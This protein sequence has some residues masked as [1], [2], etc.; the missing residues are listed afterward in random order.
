MY[1]QTTS[2]NQLGYYNRKYVQYQLLEGVKD[3]EFACLGGSGV[4]F[5]GFK[6]KCLHD[7]ELGLK[8]VNYTKNKPNL[9]VSVA[10]YKNIP[11]FTF[12][13][14]KRRDETSEWFN[15]N[16]NE[17]M[18]F[19]LFFDFDLGKDDTWESLI[20]EVNELKE[21]LDDYQVPYFVFFS[22]N[23]GVQVVIDGEYIEINE[24]KEG[25]V[26]PHKKVVENIKESL[27]L[28]TLDLS[29]NGEKSK[30]RKLPYSLVIPNQK[31]IRKEY[32]KDYLEKDMNICLPLADD[33][34]INFRL[35]SMNAFKILHSQIKIMRRGNLERFNDLELKQKKENVKQFIKVFDL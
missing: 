3:R 20:K 22:G 17:I 13:P 24:I 4:A 28:K 33:Q 10:K 23:K 19:D 1:A 6:V 5:R 32:F 18:S 27:N 25:N 35:D 29:N 14:Q 34:L 2:V 8:V 26:F 15:S 7:L 16:S 12:N 30:L 9:Y 11:K 21:Y 31:K